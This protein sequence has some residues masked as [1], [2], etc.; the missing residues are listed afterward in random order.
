[1][2][3]VETARPRE[4]GARSPLRCVAH[5]QHRRGTIPIPSDVGVLVVLVGVVIAGLAPGLATAC[6]S[7]AGAT[8]FES[9]NHTVSVT[10]P[11]SPTSTQLVGPSCSEGFGLVAPGQIANGTGQARFVANPSGHL[12]HSSVFVGGVGTGTGLASV[13]GSARW[14]VRATPTPGYAGPASVDVV[15]T[16]QA[17][18]SGSTSASGV[19][20]AGG[21]YDI[22]VSLRRADSA[23]GVILFVGAG[24]LAP[25]GTSL[26]QQSATLDV[27]FD[28]VLQISHS[29]NVQA[30]FSSGSM[31]Q[32][33]SAASS[34]T[35]ALSF[36]TVL[37]APQPELAIEY[38]VVDLLGVDPPALGQPPSFPAP[39]PLAGR[40]GLL[41]LLGVALGVGAWAVGRVRTSR[42]GAIR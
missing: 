1:M 20:S 15:V 35:V 17:D 9:G 10:L 39:I 37:D 25:G 34:G 14:V 30:S 32:A 3:R 29:Q 16:L 22:E 42:R 24:S 36:E 31:G 40:R 13:G 5:G 41:I 12:A 4:L 7:G 6:L 11:N 19:A 2:V 26:L 18:V 38:P 33:S 27:D 23:L 8:G 28:Y 21:T